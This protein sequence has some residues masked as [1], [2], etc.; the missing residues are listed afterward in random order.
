MRFMYNSRSFSNLHN[1]MNTDF[2]IPTVLLNADRH[3]LARH[4]CNVPL[5][6]DSWALPDLQSSCIPMIDLGRIIQPPLACT[7]RKMITGHDAFKSLKESGL[8][9]RCFNLRD[10]ASMAVYEYCY[11]VLKGVRV[12][13]WKSVVS[14]GRRAVPLNS[15]Q[16]H[17]DDFRL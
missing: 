9:D 3:T 7:G 15:N 11:S 12:F 13:L 2:I 17:L 4:S 10:G 16:L 1:K 6:A 8:I 5:W 14:D